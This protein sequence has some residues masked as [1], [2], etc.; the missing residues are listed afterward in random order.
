MRQ[1]TDQDFQLWIGLDAMDID[2]ARRAIGS[3]VEATWVPGVAGETL[4]Q[5][6]QRPLARI[7]EAF[8]AV[9]LVDSDDLLH[10]SRVA[11]ARE[12]LRESDFAGCALR[13]VD[14]KG[15]DLGTTLG[16]PSHADPDSVLPRNNIFGLSNTA[17]RSSLLRRCL[18]IP[19]EAVLVDWFLVTRAW[20]LGAHLAFDNELGMDYRQHGAN[21][22]RIIPP[23]DKAQVVRD[24]GR[25]RSHFSLVQ[26]SPSDG[27]LVDRLAM[28]EQVAA[29]VD[30]FHRQIISEP[31]RLEDYVQAINAL[32]MAPLWGSCVANPLLRH[33]WTSEKERA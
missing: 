27:V 3:D 26:A 22:A 13:L 12:M 21:M 7:V 30:T 4:A 15:S 29:D 23:F 2:A 10:P 16:L 14:E 11:N 24:T 8:D 5:I 17:I 18:P 20:L 9:V 1:Q 19:A 31:R 6:R 33:M 25:M 32:G 28:V